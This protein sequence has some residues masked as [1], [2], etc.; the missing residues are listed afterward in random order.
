MV[1]MESL[2][3]DRLLCSKRPRTRVVGSF[4]LFVARAGLAALLNRD[5]RLGSD[6]TPNLHT[7][8][9]VCQALAPFRW[10]LHPLVP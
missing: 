3:P 9:E 2:A 4:L 6:F 8:M 1:N 10:F 5:K 7:E